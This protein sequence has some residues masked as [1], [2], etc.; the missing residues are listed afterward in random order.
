MSEQILTV[1]TAFGPLKFI[2]TEDV[3]S[4]IL[5][6]VITLNSY[7]VLWHHLKD[8]NVLD[9]GAHKGAFT[10]MAAAAGAYVIAY[11]P[12]P[13]SF[14]I[15]ERNIELNGFGNR[16]IARRNGIWSHHETRLFCGPKDS[17]GCM[18]TVGTASPDS[19]HFKAYCIPF[20]EAVTGRQW[21]FMKMDVEG[22]EIEIINSAS[23]AALWSIQRFGMEFHGGDF[24]KIDSRLETFFR[25]E[26]MIRGSEI[27][28][29]Y[30]D[31][32]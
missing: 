32:R 11:E 2:L 29:L 18:N 4:M 14:R 27:T 23:D 5:D 6:E 19:K 22:A 7:R 8:F 31:R 25:T 12:N 28:Y 20:N 1:P 13:E 10:L 21:R 24:N 15:L 9:V 17:S 30:G 16:V 3:D 26:W